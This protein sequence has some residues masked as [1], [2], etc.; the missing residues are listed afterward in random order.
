MKLS[1][2]LF[3]LLLTTV[4]RPLNAQQMSLRVPGLA[5]HN[6]LVQSNST[7]DGH[8][9]HDAAT[10][11]GPPT[12]VSMPVTGSA[13]FYR[14]LDMP[15]GAFWWNWEYH[16]QADL[17]AVNWYL[18]TTQVFYLH[19]DRPYEWFV[20]QFQTSPCGGG[21]CFPSSVVMGC[22]WRDQHSL[23]TV[24]DALA[25][26]PNTNCAGWYTDQAEHYLDDQGVPWRYTSIYSNDCC[27]K[28]TPANLTNELA[29]GNLLLV[30]LDLSYI[31]GNGSG[32]RRALKC[33]SC[34][35]FHAVIVKG[36]RKTLTDANWSWQPSILW[37]E[38]Y[39]PAPCAYWQDGEP[40][41][42]NRHYEF[43]QVVSAMMNSFWYAYVIPPIGAPQPMANQTWRSPPFGPIH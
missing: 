5:G 38:V 8:F 17:G 7:V 23:A 4:P 39:D 1:V 42:K 22:R 28:G 40:D 14:V 36:F 27:L 21:N 12:S 15:T 10:V 30:C 41:T 32:E 19:L 9:W 43:N 13:G 35:G 29:H 16:R 6:Y 26:Y 34:Y 20:N 18:G 11:T 37:L 24:E 33:C 31:S 25:R 3:L 2:W